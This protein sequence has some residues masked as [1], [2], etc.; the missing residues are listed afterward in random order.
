[1]LA[2]IEQQRGPEPT[3][4]DG[5][6]FHLFTEQEQ[7]ELQLFLDQIEP[8]I[9]EVDNR[10]LQSLSDSELDT[11][12]VWLLLEHALTQEDINAAAKYRHQLTTLAVA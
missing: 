7:I 6:H 8:K 4:Q 12:E 11:L 1:M 10:P 2:A 9:N 3:A 5:F